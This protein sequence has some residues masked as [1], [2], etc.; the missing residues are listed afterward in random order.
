MMAADLRI[1]AYSACGSPKVL[2]IG[3]SAYDWNSAP[4]CSWREWSG[5]L[6]L[7]RESKIG[8]VQSMGQCF[9]SQRS[10]TQTQ[11]VVVH[12]YAQ[13]SLQYT[14]PSRTTPLPGDTVQKQRSQAH[15]TA[16]SMASPHTP[17]VARFNG[18]VKPNDVG[19]LLKRVCRTGGVKGVVIGLTPISGP[20][21]ARAM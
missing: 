8:N 7:N 17:I 16:W 9:S 3:V 6:M 4:D 10:W 14:L 12:S 19:S 15:L 13:V 2:T 18:W 5:L 20:P 1:A 11:V 21:D